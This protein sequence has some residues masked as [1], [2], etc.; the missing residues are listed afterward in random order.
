MKRNINILFCLVLVASLAALAQSAPAPANTAAADPRP[1]AAATTKIGIIN[2]QQAIVASNEGQRDFKALQDKLAPKQNEL[3]KLNTEIND[4]KKQLD[5][6]GDKL[7]EQARADLAK[8]LD[9]KQKLLQRNGEDY[10][11]DVQQQQNEIAQRILE[12]MGPVIDKYAKENQYAL[13]IDVSQPWPQGE[14]LWAGPSVDITKAVVD[15][16]NAQSGVPAPPAAAPASRPG[17]AAAPRP[18]A[19]SA[20]RPA[21]T[22][23]KPAPKPPGR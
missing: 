13:I 22:T 16:Y 11:S 9:Q 5:T 17:A 23:A 1:T 15:I 21:S 18:S 4:L 3:Q 20:T 12:K 14:V 19:P 10:Q 2:V 6:Q 8:S 7:N